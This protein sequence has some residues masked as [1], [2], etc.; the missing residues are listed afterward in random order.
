MDNRYDIDNAKVIGR[1]LP[2]FIRGRK[3]SMF[4]YAIAY[5][6]VTL[7]ESFKEWALQKKMEASV[8]SQTLTME[9]YL[10]YLFKDKFE[11]ETASFKITDSI[12]NPENIAYFTTERVEDYW[13]TAP[14]YDS[15][16]SSETM[17][18]SNTGEFQDQDGVIII[19]PKIV[20]ISSYSTDDYIK[21]ICKTVDT[22][23]TNFKKYQIVIK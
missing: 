5:P 19:A 21:D 6:L 7:H 3:L 12:D 2:F 16:E 8:T 11:D 15:E 23:I 9:W 14:V 20:E 18:I 22:Y 4:L 10:T 1:I 13:N 17:V